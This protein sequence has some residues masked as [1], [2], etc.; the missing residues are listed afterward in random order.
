MWTPAMKSFVTRLVHKYHDELKEKG[1]PV[2]EIRE[3]KFSRSV[4]T[5]GSCTNYRFDNTCTITISEVAFSGGNETLKN[6]ILHELTHSIRGCK[7]HGEVWQRYADEIGSMYGVKIQQYVSEEEKVACKEY[8]ESR[9]NWKVT[10]PSCGHTWKYYRKTK[11][12]DILMNG[13]KCT[14]SCG[15]DGNDFKVE[16]LKKG[17]KIYGI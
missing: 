16:S 15:Y 9:Y 12:I 7:G 17:V 10:C 3:V 5:H 11:V 8:K 2:R 1:Y 13:R 4:K 14:C 6:T